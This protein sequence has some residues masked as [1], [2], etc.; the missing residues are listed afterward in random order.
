MLFYP[1][2]D[3][4]EMYPWAEPV[5]EFFAADRILRGRIAIANVRDYV[6]REFNRQVIGLWVRFNDWQDIRLELRPKLLT[7]EEWA[8][9]RQE[10]HTGTV[11]LE[12]VRAVVHAEAETVRA[13]NTRWSGR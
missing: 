10:L 9:L 1:G 4:A 12:D 5:T 3:E 13:F 2:S 8:T 7:A 11:S 6:F